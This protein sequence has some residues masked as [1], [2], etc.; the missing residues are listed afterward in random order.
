MFEMLR[1]IFAAF[2]PW[3]HAFR[4]L[5]EAAAAAAESVKL[6]SLNYRDE[7]IIQNKA[8]LKAL[9]KQLETTQ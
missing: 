4:D 3:S 9:T 8:G 2:I 5:G 1:N 7:Q 6:S